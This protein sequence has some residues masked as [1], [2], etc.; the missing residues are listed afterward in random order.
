MYSKKPTLFVK[1]NAKKQYATPR[2]EIVEIDF[3]LSVLQASG[4]E[5]GEDG[6]TGTINP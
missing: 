3:S 5:A 6:G 1:E 4:G 2:V